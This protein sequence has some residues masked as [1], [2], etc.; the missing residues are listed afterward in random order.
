MVYLE[1]LC[2]INLDALL[3]CPDEDLFQHDVSNLLDLALGQ[4]AEHNDLVQ[5]VQE[6][7]PAGR[8]Q[9]SVGAIKFYVHFYVFL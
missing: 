6:L 2:D 8:Q 1:A 5:P 4:L 9:L 7:W 3:L